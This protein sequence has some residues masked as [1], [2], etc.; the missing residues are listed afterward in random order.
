ML[1]TAQLHYPVS[2]SQP[3]QHM[4]CC[5][6]GANTLHDRFSTEA[7]MASQLSPPAAPAL[8]PPHPACETRTA[9][10][11]LSRTCFALAPAAADMSGQGGGPASARWREPQ[12]KQKQ[13]RSHILIFNMTRSYTLCIQYTHITKRRQK[14]RDSERAQEQDREQTYAV[15]H[16]ILQRIVERTA[17]CAVPGYVA[18]YE[19]PFKVR[20]LH[21]WTLA[22]WTSH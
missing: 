11:H 10:P 21:P 14:K 17:T 5:P 3:K 13:R 18:C 6:D 8:A 16:D 7:F 12:A 15:Q 9:K 19:R 1:D 2:S 22:T 20:V 4:S